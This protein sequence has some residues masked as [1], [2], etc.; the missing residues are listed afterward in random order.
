MKPNEL[1][2]RL[3]FQLFLAFTILSVS[4]L[5]CVAAG[6]GS[7]SNFKFGSEYVSFIVTQC[8]R[9]IEVNRTL[10]YV[11]SQLEGGRNFGD[12]E[13][14]MEFVRANPPEVV[15]AKRKIYEGKLELKR[16]LANKAAKE[17]AAEA[18]QKAAEKAALREAM[19]ASNDTGGLDLIDSSFDDSE[20]P[21]SWWEWLTFPFWS[22]P[23]PATPEDVSSD[24]KRK[25][26]PL[27]KIYHMETTSDDPL[28]CSVSYSSYSFKA[29]VKALRDILM[30]WDDHNINGFGGGRLI[31]IGYAGFGGQ[32]WRNALGSGVIQKRDVQMAANPTSWWSPE[33][34]RKRDYFR[35]RRMASSSDYNFRDPTTAVALIDEPDQSSSQVIDWMEG[36]SRRSRISSWNTTDLPVLHS[37]SPIEPP[38]IPIAEFDPDTPEYARRIGEWI[39]MKLSVCGIMRGPIPELVAMYRFQWVV[40]RI[41]EIGSIGPDG[42]KSAAVVLVFVKAEGFRN[43]SFGRKMRSPMS[44]LRAPG[45]SKAEAAHGA[46]VVWILALAGYHNY[47]KPEVAVT[48]EGMPILPLQPTTTLVERILGTMGGIGVLVAV[49]RLWIRYNKRTDEDEPAKELYSFANIY[50]FVQAAGNFLFAISTFVDGMKRLVE[51]IGL[52]EWVLF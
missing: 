46:L 44:F 26:T 13:R 3:P 8:T 20:K 52:M 5:S 47:E 39:L 28:G 38:A 16:A 49:A 41:L 2:L 7:I 34:R 27:Y 9:S 1:L 6:Y 11:I 45:V 31:G 19:M 14:M 32:L 29:V 48:L 12:Y 30:A 42:S 36:S 21:L 10:E 33:S 50:S 22:A 37:Q 51:V 43:R 25:P 4:Q 35:R 15:E 18:A 23:T 17:A 24:V 40:V